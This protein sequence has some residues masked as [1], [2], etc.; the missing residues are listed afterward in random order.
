M[1]CDT[2][3]VSLAVPSARACP[4]SLAMIIIVQPRS[5]KCMYNRR[6]SVHVKISTN[7]KQIPQVVDRSLTNMINLVI[8]GHVLVK[9][10][11]K[12]RYF[13]WDGDL[14]ISKVQAPRRN[15]E[16]INKI[17]VFSGFSLKSFCSIQQLI[18]DIQLRT[19]SIDEFR[20]SVLKVIR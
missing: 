19:R 4:R 16:W 9:N 13:V 8:K 17:S 2:F 18:S 11:S 3:L 20:S 1:L 6:C 5:Y 15:R 14:F 7:S 10:D 12:A